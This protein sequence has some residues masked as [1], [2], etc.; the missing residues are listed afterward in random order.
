MISTE[1]GHENNRFSFFTSAGSSE[2]GFGNFVTGSYSA[3]YQSIR[4]MRSSESDT[5]LPA[6]FALDIPTLGLPGYAVLVTLFAFAG[7]VILIR[8]KA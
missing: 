4:L 2:F 7:W 8:F 1:Y 5:V 3:D 6:A